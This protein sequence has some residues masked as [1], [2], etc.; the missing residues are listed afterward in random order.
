MPLLNY[1]TKIPATQTIAEIMVILVS[2]GASEIMTTYG[3]E[4]QAVGLKWRIDT[5]A[6]GYLGFALPVDAY[7]VFKILTRQGI[8]PNNNERR[9]E[10]SVRV[11][12]RIIKVWIEAQMA[13]LETGMV[14]M[15]EVF[16]PY[17]LTGD[18]TVYQAIRERGF[19]ALPAPQREE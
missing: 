11:A 14:Q 10:Q 1:S 4:G 13:L 9:A 6:H 18:Q 17:M 15:E 12:W 7:A 19:K 3:Q 8:W 2:K 16:L 5:Q